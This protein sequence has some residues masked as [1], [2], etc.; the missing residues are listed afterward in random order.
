M[1]EGKMLSCSCDYDDS[2]RWYYIP[3]NFSTFTK[4]RR[5]RCCSC[6]TL[7]D[8]NSQCVEFDRNRAPVSEIEERI[9]GSEISLANWFMCEKCGEIFLNLSALGYCIN[10]DKNMQEYLEDYWDLTGFTP[11][12][13]CDEPVISYDEMVKRLEDDE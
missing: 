7:I 5:K 2:D 13:T 4:K 10:L 3:D 6:N 11:K 9:M 12:P 8:I 1:E